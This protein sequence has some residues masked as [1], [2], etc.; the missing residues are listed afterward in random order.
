MKAGWGISILILVLGLACT[1]PCA[2]F[3]NTRKIAAE[4]LS[5]DRCQTV[6]LGPVDPGISSASRFCLE[7]FPRGRYAAK[8]RWT[9]VG[10]SQTPK[11]P[12]SRPL[13]AVL[14]I[15]REDGDLQAESEL[16]LSSLLDGLT[17]SPTG[18]EGVESP[19]ETVVIDEG[20]GWPGHSCTTG[21]VVMAEPDRYPKPE[22]SGNFEIREGQEFCVVVATKGADSRAV[23]YRFAAAVTLGW[24]PW[25]PGDPEPVPCK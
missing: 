9:K 6:E 16:D 2:V 22:R 15:Y 17:P 7:G 23:D 21:L 24:K 25:V 5:L 8:L 11:N 10:N 3:N 14:R 1:S 12:G 13:R 20:W 18:A 4:N 19:E